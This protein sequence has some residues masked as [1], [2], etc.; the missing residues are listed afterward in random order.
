[1]HLNMH[2]LHGVSHSE[3]ANYTEIDMEINEE[4]KMPRYLS[5][6][7]ATSMDIVGIRKDYVW[8]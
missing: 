4:R 3:K 5:V 7:L 6:I 2:I 8:T 1:M